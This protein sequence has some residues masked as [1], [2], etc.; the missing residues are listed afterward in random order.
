MRPAGRG[1]VGQDRTIAG[2]RRDRFGAPARRSRKADPAR[3]A[4]DS[5]GWFG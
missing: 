2:F 1:T 4:E 5:V 3:A